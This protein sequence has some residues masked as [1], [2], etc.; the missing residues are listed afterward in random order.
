MGAP[1]VS[2]IVHIPLH[3]NEPLITTAGCIAT[4]VDGCL[5]AECAPHIPPGHSI[6]TVKKHS[7]LALQL[8][9][10]SPSRHSPRRTSCASTTT[11]H[12]NTGTPKSQTPTSRILLS[13]RQLPPKR[14][15][16]SL[17]PQEALLER[18]QCQGDGEGP[19]SLP[20]CPR[21]KDRS[22]GVARPA[23]GEARPR[24]SDRIRMGPAIVRP[25]SIEERI[26]PSHFRRITSHGHRTRRCR[27]QRKYS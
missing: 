8:G 26:R 15:K 18:C 27:W 4:S 16:A 3:Q 14:R 19:G 24:H 7:Q 10:S 1:W 5:F 22:K 17:A 13:R 9:H 21:R 12:R 20:R 2:S 25:T 11:S 23:S 6:H